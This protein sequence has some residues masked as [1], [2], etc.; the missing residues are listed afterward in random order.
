MMYL[1]RVSYA[2][3]T[4][5]STVKVQLIAPLVYFY[6]ENYAEDDSENTPDNFNFGR[7]FK[8]AKIDK[9]QVVAPLLEKGRTSRILSKYQQELILDFSSHAILKEYEL[10]DIEAMNISNSKGYKEARRLLHLLKM[11]LGIA[12]RSHLIFQDFHVKNGD[13]GA[14]ASTSLNLEGSH[15]DG[16]AYY[17]V[18]NDVSFLRSDLVHAK[19]IFEH[20]VKLSDEYS[21]VFNACYYFEMARLKGDGDYRLRFSLLVT[22]MESIF[23]INTDRIAETLAL[24][25]PLLI[26][27]NPDKRLEVHKD[28]KDI[29]KLR[30]YIVHGQQIPKRFLKEEIQ[31]Q[32]L[33]KLEYYTRELILYIFNNGL[34]DTINS[35]DVADYFTGNI[36]GLDH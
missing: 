33:G 14:A 22:S 2:I 3:I 9:A 32:L 8:L 34:V 16:Q 7:G 18:D 20:L 13:V 36:L 1:L 12:K 19:T 17:P 27:D 35:N 25:Y 15:W 30:S 21:R 24:R 29:Y 23:N 5:M 10:T 11:A 31:D 26:Y 4:P 6:P 28:L